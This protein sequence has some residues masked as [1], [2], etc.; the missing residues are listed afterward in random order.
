[1][2]IA[3]RTP[4]EFVCH[5]HCLLI[6]CTIS[7]AN[8]QRA[9]HLDKKNLSFNSYTMDIQHKQEGEAGVFFISD[10]NNDT[11]AELVYAQKQPGTMVIEHT[12]VDKA[13]RGKDVGDQLIYG[14]VAYARSNDLKIMPVCSFARAVFELKKE[15]KDVYVRPDQ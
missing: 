10:D 9:R 2:A 12:E 7:Y 15:Y 14:A 8:M 11:I 4:F 5:H 3:Y 6:N 1:M 13:F